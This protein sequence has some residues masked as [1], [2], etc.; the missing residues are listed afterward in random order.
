[1]PQFLTKEIADALCTVIT[2]GF[3]KTQMDETSK[4]MVFQYAE[5]S[6]KDRYREVQKG[7]QKFGVNI[8]VGKSTDQD[9]MPYI[10]GT[11]L[12]GEKLKNFIASLETWVAAKNAMMDRAQGEDAPRGAYIGVQF[13]IKENGMAVAGKISVDGK[14]IEVDPVIFG[15][16]ALLQYKL[17]YRSPLNRTEKEA[18]CNAYTKAK[19]STNEAVRALI[20]SKAM[21]EDWKYKFDESYDDSKGLFGSSHGMIRAM[22]NCLDNPPGYK[23][24]FAEIALGT[25]TK[26]VSSCVPCAI[27]M[28]SF[29]YPASSI[30]LGRGDNWVLDSG[31]YENRFGKIREKN[32]AIRQKWRETV[33]DYYR[34][35]RTCVEKG[36]Y[37]SRAFETA[38][39]NIANILKVCKIENTEG[40][41]PDIF[42]ESLTFE[43]SFTD[44]I[45]NTLK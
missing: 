8:T 9:T 32:A 28:Q 36:F 6:E 4:A 15:P 45:I 12:T 22:V 40:E 33:I 17:Q 14:D 26:K 7:F 39:P 1:M 24:V 38:F 3:A 11:D 20:N 44:R 21:G 35:G 25:N 16:S 27:F 41:I 42:L 34:A 30:H 19:T 37:D 31:V 29:G 18:I 5:D 23:S 2:L 10:L 13:F 43:G